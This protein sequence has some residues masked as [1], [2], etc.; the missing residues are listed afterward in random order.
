MKVKDALFI[1]MLVFIGIPLVG[2]LTVAIEMF[3]G[4]I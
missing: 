4:I 1:F 2:L 3:R